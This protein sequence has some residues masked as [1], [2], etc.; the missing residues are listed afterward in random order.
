MS[1]YAGVRRSRVRSLA[2]IKLE[3]CWRG[4]L[5]RKLVKKRMWAAQT[6]RKYIK[7]F[8]CRKQPVN[9]DNK[10]FVRF[11]Q[12]TY[13][14]KLRDHLPTGVLDQTWLKPPEI[15]EETSEFLRKICIRNLSVKYCR[16]APAVRKAQLDQKV[17]ASAIFRGKKAGYD[18]SRNEHFADTRISE[19]ELSPKVM[20]M[21]R[22][23]KVKYVTRV[24]KFD[25]KAYK[26]RERLLVLTR[27]AA[28]ILESGKIKH[29]IEYS[30][31]KAVS[32]S[33][34]SDGTVV[35]HVLE[36]CKL[37]K[38]D[39]ILQCEHVFEMVTRLAILAKNPEL[40]RVVQGR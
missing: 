9:V 27:V 23:E 39:A 11:A 22:H 21:I 8:I 34:L 2:A 4:V 37:E 13:L 5:A 32:T 16:T 38:A 17:V 7:G 15:M 26:P 36:E 12:Y 14:L 1:I 31:I 40:V 25:P 19:S 30:G 10:D 29:K 35:I 6:I 28:Y 33:D 24:L 20:Q 18:R 3:S